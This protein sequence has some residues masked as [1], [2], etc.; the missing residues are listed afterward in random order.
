MLISKL[1]ISFSI[2]DNFALRTILSATS[3]F[4][5]ARP[6][7]EMELLLLSFELSP[8]RARAD[9]RVAGMSGGQHHEANYHLPSAK[10]S[11]KRRMESRTH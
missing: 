7:V 6:P 8:I 2:F 10:Q 11:E 1:T 3:R 4:A 5:P 9:G